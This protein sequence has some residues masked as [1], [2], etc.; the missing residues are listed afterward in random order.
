MPLGLRSSAICC[1]MLTDA[2]VF[3]FHQDQF[4]AVNYIDDL[5]GAETEDKAWNA[6]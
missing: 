6:F 1:Q 3:I 2:I 5:G 4:D